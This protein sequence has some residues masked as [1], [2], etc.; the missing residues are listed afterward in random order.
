VHGWILQV[1]EGFLWHRLFPFS[2]CK[3]KTQV[4]PFFLST[5]ITC[6]LCHL[7]SSLCLYF[8]PCDPTVKSILKRP[9][10]PWSPSVHFP[11]S[12]SPNRPS[13]YVYELPPWFNTWQFRN[14]P[15]LDWPDAMVLTERILAS[16]HRTADMSKADFFFIPLILRY[17]E[18]FPSAMVVFFF[19]FLPPT[20]PLL[21]QEPR[22][23]ENASLRG[24]PRVHPDHLA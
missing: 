1:Q 24:R 23:H 4:C 11:K 2:G 15:R 10:F 14:G 22:V 13:V 12:P 18:L 16:G 8:C 3:G 17:L 7:P 5:V 20:Q 6:L 19:L 21:I 9:P